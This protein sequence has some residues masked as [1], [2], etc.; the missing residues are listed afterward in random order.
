MYMHLCAISEVVPLFFRTLGPWPSVTWPQP[1]HLQW[2]KLVGSCLA[3]WDQRRCV[4][5]RNKL[6]KKYEL[7][8][9]EEILILTTVTLKSKTKL[10]SAALNTS[11]IKMKRPLWLLVIC[12][13]IKSKYLI[14]CP[15]PIWNGLIPFPRCRSDHDFSIRHTSNRKEAVHL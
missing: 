12:I 10:H 6:H 1:W 9:A 13:W 7:E 11:L 8:V 4:F 15:I 2:W 5:V 14:S 3:D